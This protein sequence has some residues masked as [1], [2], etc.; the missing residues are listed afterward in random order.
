MLNMVIK[1]TVLDHYSVEN[2][3]KRS[4]AKKK[5]FREK[6]LTALKVLMPSLQKQSK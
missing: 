3:R 4:Q 5:I 2:K 1:L 6:M